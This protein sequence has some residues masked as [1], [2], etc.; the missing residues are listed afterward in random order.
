MKKRH[1]FALNN[2]FTNGAP[3]IRG[4]HVAYWWRKYIK[5]RGGAMKNYFSVAHPRVIGK[6]WGGPPLEWHRKT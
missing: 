6:N 5:Y 3:Y 1:G 4:H 2:I